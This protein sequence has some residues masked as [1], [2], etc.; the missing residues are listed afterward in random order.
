M[1]RGDKYFYNKE[2]IQ[3][4]QSRESQWKPKQTDSIKYII[5]VLGFSFR[6]LETHFIQKQRKLQLTDI[7]SIINFITRLMGQLF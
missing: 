1:Y 6:I 5:F 3:E 7:E 2:N 4:W